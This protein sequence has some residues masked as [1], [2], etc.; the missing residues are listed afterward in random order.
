[1]FILLIFINLNVASEGRATIVI[2]EIMY[3]PEQND[4][5]NEWIE[6]YNPTNHSINVSGWSITDNFAE[7][8]LE[9]DRDHG[10]GTTIIPAYGHAIIADHGTKI[11]ENFSIPFNTT[12]LYID[13]S[14]IGNGLGNNED[15]LILKNST[16]NFSDA[17][18][19][20]YDY[21]DVPGIPTDLVDEGHSLSRHSDL[22]TN[23]SIIDF[24]D[25]IIPTP[26]I[27]NKFIQGGNLDIT[28]CPSHIPKIHNNYEYGIPF[29]IKINISNYLPDENYQLKAYVV[30]NISSS[31]P[32]SQTWD[33]TSW[34]YS[35]QYVFNI[36]TDEH[37][38]WTD[39]IYLRFKKEYKEY[40]RNI[41]ENDTAYVNVKIRKDDSSDEI[42]NAI[43]LMDMDK[44]TSNATSGGCVIGIA[45]EN[46]TFLQ[47]KI[48]IVENH[49]GVITGIYAT[50][51]N[52]ID[53]DLTS[54]SGYYKLT[55]PVGSNY[56][57]KI[58]DGGYNVIHVFPNVTIKQ[59]KYG[60]NINSPET[61][62]MIKRRETLDIP[63]TLKNTGDFNDTVQVSI[64]QVTNGW[65]A[66][67]EKKAISLGPGE[68]YNINLHILPCKHRKREFS[69]T[70][71]DVLI[72]SEK[73]IGESDKITFYIN[74]IA[75]DLTIT[76]IKIYDEDNNESDIFGQGE[77]IKI[78]AF[79]KNIGNENAT[80]ASAM[81]YYDYIDEEHFIGSKSYESIG[82]YQ[83]YP[84]MKWDT[85]DVEP[86]V[87]T[88][89]VIAD[90]NERIDELDEFDNEMSVEVN[91]FD[92][93]PVKDG[94]HLLI[95]E[96]YYHTHSRVNNEF[97]TI[98]NPTNH[99]FNISGWYITNQPLKNRGDQ[100]K[101][102]FPDNTTIASEAFLCITQ[103]ASAFTWETGGKPD[104][105]YKVDSSDDVPQMCSSKQFTLSNNGA[106]IALKSFYNHTIDILAYGESDYNCSGWNGLP[107]PSSGTGT[108]LK[109]NFNQDVPVDTNTSSDWSHPRRYGIGQSDFPLVNISFSGEVR[110]F[111]SPD[112]SFETIVSELRKANESIY[113]NIYE[114]TNPFLC[115]ELVAA[116]RR[117]VSVNI[118]LEGSPIG[119]ISDRE[120]FILNRISTYGGNIRL[121]VNDEKN[122][123]HARYTFDHGK[124]LVIDNNTAIVESCNWAKTGIPKDPTF[125]NREW[126]I[127]IKS[128]TIA[129]Y[130]LGVFLDDWNPKRCDSYSFYDMDFSVPPDYYMDNSV[131][132]GSYEPQFIS[133]TITGNFS[134][135]PVFS[136]DTSYKA[137][138]DIIESAN[139]SIYIEQLYIYRDWDNG[140]SPFVERLVNKSKK[141]VDIKVILN[142]NPH[143]GAT[144]EKCNLTKQYF[145][146]NG[147]E[148]K[149]IY[150]NWS[151]FSNIH[152][153]GMI[154]DNESVLIASINWN[155]NSVTRNREAGIIIENEEVAQYYTEA[156]FYDWNL[157][158]P[159][160][161][162][163]K[164]SQQ[165]ENK[166]TIYISLINHFI[167]SFTP[168]TTY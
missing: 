7:D 131:Y 91:I 152:N 33:G 102:I 94:E 22:D 8:F 15:K 30:G 154:V 146:E 44:S 65:G 151:Y 5:Y 71:V 31:W 68:E 21:K 111:V 60:V 48:I 127:V 125:G 1:M 52:E 32:A 98:Y 4:N 2:N 106:M 164:E 57:V 39:W 70:N 122:N 84:S 43:F 51:D 163:A 155:E 107:I 29:A 83:K 63:L 72:T 89:F 97:I 19:W 109:R 162:D 168:V 135:I 85:I 12:R 54:K 64:D 114:F 36:T 49:T 35:D 145:E 66:E 37:G 25:G 133:K 78:K 69:G 161:Q 148:V 150:S 3:D 90:G 139:E 56:T 167:Y 117:N 14:N 159:Q 112:C 149:F 59:G 123:I 34:M 9:G 113:F 67:I 119:G 77:T 160:P 105:E 121:I 153:K 61:S 156:F 17:V 104:F 95:T 62:Y 140:M 118:F 96:V 81:F 27:K 92:T 108:V 124:Y 147:V 126:G 28:L 46:N 142:Y 47:N 75:P 79:L 166:K 137:I 55:S 103:N 18:E 82:K 129:E 74:I 157:T 100:R 10:N 120:K 20:S 132:R 138:C 42:S 13:D 38:N 128:K 76:N 144:N 50:E 40:Q 23:N 136:P 6:L 134:A 116:L 26:G 73:D 86:G 130:F 41:K 16:G 11:Y 87:H 143:Y 141:G 88:V 80:D 165:L 115:D 158:Q 93:Y 45:E 24:Y 53:D 99:S 101:I 110:T 58:L